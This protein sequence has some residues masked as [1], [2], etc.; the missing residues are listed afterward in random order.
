MFVLNRIIVLIKDWLK[1]IKNYNKIVLFIHLH[2]MNLS[3]NIYK[4]GGFYAI[5]NK[6]FRT[7]K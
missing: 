5:E 7:I 3:D 1:H 4:K 6:N 2:Q